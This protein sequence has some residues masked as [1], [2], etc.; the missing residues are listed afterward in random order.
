M[1]FLVGRE[2]PVELDLLAPPPSDPLADPLACAADVAQDRFADQLAKWKVPIAHVVSATLTGETVRGRSSVRGR[3]EQ[4]SV[5][6]WTVCVRTATGQASRLARDVHVAL[7]DLSSSPGVSGEVEP[8]AAAPSTGAGR[9]TR[10]RRR[11][12][13]A[14]SEQE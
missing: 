14:A 5:M 6:R 8:S 10:R 1:G 9:V 2:S 7:H 11:G 13:V 4:G 3:H 12:G